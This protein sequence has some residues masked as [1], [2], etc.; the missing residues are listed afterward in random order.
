[1]YLSMSYIHHFCVIRLLRWSTHTKATIIIIYTPYSILYTPHMHV[2][3]GRS[4]EMHACRLLSRTSK[5]TAANVR[6]GDT[7]TV[8][9]SHTHSWLHKCQKTCVCTLYFPLQHNFWRSIIN[10]DTFVYLS[11]KLDRC[12]P[13][14]FTLYLCL[15]KS[16]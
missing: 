4:L 8:D 15:V 11:N 13:D 16:P 6:L 3:P 12:V 9:H 10:H 7:Q 5:A 14:V 2:H 1:M